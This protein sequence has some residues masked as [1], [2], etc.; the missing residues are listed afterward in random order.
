MEGANGKAL[1]TLAG[2]INTAHD[3]FGMIIVKVDKEEDLWETDD[4]NFT[5]ARAS[6]SPDRIYF[7]EDT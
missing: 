4:N 2:C 3:L 7:A 1:E 6:I 5:A